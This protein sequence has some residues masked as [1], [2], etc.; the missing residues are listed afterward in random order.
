LVV[1]DT[2]AK[3]EERRLVPIPDNLAQWLQPH[4]K[5]SGPVC[6]YTNLANVYAHLAKR[7]KLEWKR[8]GL[9]HSFISYRTALTK[10]VPQVA[11]EAGN[12]PQMIQRHYL[13]IV[14]ESVAK[15]WF[16]I[17][18]KQPLNVIPAVQPAEAAT[19]ALA[20]AV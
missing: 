2:V 18:P 14:T 12:S 19:P 3:C 11:F 13:K 8:N 6:S 15:Q 5:T 17:M 20:Q 10:N 4:C 9:R 7:A 1:P 16:A